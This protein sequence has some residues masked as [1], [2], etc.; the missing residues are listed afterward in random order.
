MKSE[1]ASGFSDIKSILADM[2]KRGVGDVADA[3]VGHGK[4]P[5]PAATPPGSDNDSVFGEDMPMT[6]EMHANF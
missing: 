4:G 2:Q 1:Q 6:M 3:H 5:D